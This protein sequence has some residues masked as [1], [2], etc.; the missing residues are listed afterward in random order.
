MS[1]K[2]EPL[3]DSIELVPRFR[4]QGYAPDEVSL[5]RQW[6]EA[7]CG[8]DLRHVALHSIPSEQMRGNIENPIGAVQMPLGIAGPLLVEGEYARGVFYVPFATTEGALVRSYER[9][10]VALTRS[11][12]VRVRVEADENRVCP[13]FL[14][15]DVADAAR[16]ARAVVT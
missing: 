9:G 13:V 8:V 1:K 3:P 14:F 12:G 7:R 2:V 10:M 4:K 16:F 15:D 5:R 6:I 11:G